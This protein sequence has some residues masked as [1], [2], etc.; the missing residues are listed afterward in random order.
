MY[1]SAIGYE[2]PNKDLKDVTGAIGDFGSLN[3]VSKALSYKM[4]K[5]TV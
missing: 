2:D 5:M 3:Q 1:N 4:L